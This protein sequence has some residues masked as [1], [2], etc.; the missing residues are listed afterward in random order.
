MLLLNFVKMGDQGSLNGILVYTSVGPKFGKM[1]NN[2]RIQDLKIPVYAENYEECDGTIAGSPNLQKVT[3]FDEI[4][5][6][7]RIVVRT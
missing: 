6:K 4:L 7:K 3:V 5:L 1:S 2:D